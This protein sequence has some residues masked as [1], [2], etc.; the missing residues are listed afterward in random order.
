MSEQKGVINVDNK[1]PV[2]FQQSFPLSYCFK[3]LV[4]GNYVECFIASSEHRY[5]RSAQS[6]SIQLTTSVTSII[7]TYCSA[8]LISIC[9]AS[10]MY[11]SKQ[12]FRHNFETDFSMSCLLSTSIS[13]E[14]TTLRTYWIHENCL[15]QRS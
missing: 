15:V 11:G 6:I 2:E 3:Y 1:F 5:I 9:N 8:I 13:S 12:F 10:E 4:G 14:L 7:L